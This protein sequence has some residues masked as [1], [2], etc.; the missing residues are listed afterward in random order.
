MAMLAG[1]RRR[2]QYNVTPRGKPL[3][4]DKNRFGTKMLEKM[5]WSKGKGLGANEDGSTDFVRV[6]YKDSVDGLGYKAR[7]DQ[8]T[9]HEQVFDGL[10][11]SL[12]GDEG[13]ID[14][15]GET[16][17]MET[18]PIGFGFKQIEKT[19]KPN[20]LKEKISGISLEEKSK[21][22]RARVHYK[23]FTRG[24]DLSQYSE[25]DLAN[26]FGKKE[27]ENGL[28]NDPWKAQ[29]IQ[30]EIGPNFS[31]V[32]TI[33]TGLSL[34]DYFKEKMNAKKNTINTGNEAVDKSFLNNDEEDSLSAKVNGCIEPVQDQKKRKRKDKEQKCSD[35]AAVE[36]STR[37]RKKTEKGVE[38]LKES[39]VVETSML[40]SE[41][42]RK[43]KPDTQKI[44]NEIVPEKVTTG[45]TEN[46]D[47]NENEISLDATTR[48][49]K[50]KKKHNVDFVQTETQQATIT[51]A[52]ENSAPKITENRDSNETETVLD[53]TTSKHKKKKK[54]KRDDRANLV[55]SDMRDTTVAEICEE[56]EAEKKKS[57]KKLGCVIENQ[58]EEIDTGINF[59]N[60]KKKHKREQI[61]QVEPD[62]DLEKKK[63]AANKKLEIHQEEQ[64]ASLSGI[65]PCP[66]NEHLESVS[67]KKKKKR[68][69]GDAELIADN[70]NKSVE[71]N[72]HSQTDDTT[73]MNKKTKVSEDT[74]EHSQTDDTTEMNKKT[75]KNFI[76]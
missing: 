60:K 39:E 35:E 65:T 68:K 53:E 10:L 6:N 75:K 36:P 43:N 71:T 34:T 76:W 9:A 64:S 3:Y 22:S 73:E 48:K 44:T 67:S 70:Y 37:K 2:K 49:H 32:Q 54:S 56:A 52:F 12:N 72:E 62:S 8:W 55:R 42:K 20:K 14:P 74:S 61:E 47:I 15:A 59:G 27:A 7:D 4:D 58:T 1:P 30:N 13:A 31:G 5:G 17:D 66:N 46:K 57:K 50:K 33:T 25:K 63:L 21:Q 26:I 41:K 24:K 18:R 38:D 19:V 16:S 29:V 69:K 51:G 40:K 23:K 28:P 11:Q 45:N